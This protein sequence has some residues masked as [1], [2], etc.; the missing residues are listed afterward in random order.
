VTKR[1]W[2]FPDPARRRTVDASV[3]EDECEAQMPIN[4]GQVDF[5][6]D[7]REAP[8][9]PVPV[10]DI[11]PFAAGSE[12]DR[13]A[14]AEQV[15]RACQEIGFLVITGHGVPARA[16]GAVYEATRSFYALPDDEKMAVASPMGDPFHGYAPISLVTPGMRGRP[17]LR[18]MFHINRYDTPEAAVAA[19][20]PPD[21]ESSMPPNLWPARPDGFAEA[22][23]AYYL[24]MEALAGRLFRIFAVALGLAEEFFDDKID[25][26]VSNLAA[27]C[28]PEQPDP[29]E[30]GQLRSSAHVDFASMT[31]LYQ[32]D[33]PGGLQVYQR[34]A[35][36][37]AVPSLPGSFVVN[38]GDLMARWTNERWVAT[39]HRVVNPPRDSAMT[40]RFSVP[41]FHLPNHDALIEAI[42]TCVSPATPARYAPVIA[43]EWAHERRLGR[44][45]MYGRISA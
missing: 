27:N 3:D 6:H 23:R 31:I 30:P 21:I 12:A 16:I 29:P 38:L 39:P 10:I 2:T 28:Y 44:P 9:S 34:G 26:H 42:A 1:V 5:E 17:D 8:G 33:A 11:G 43:G 45:A 13:R 25:R 14:I 32:D 7:T 20:Y 15:D 19:G 18:E 41:F 35:G 36:W 4:L 22:W 40:R 24:E 37:R